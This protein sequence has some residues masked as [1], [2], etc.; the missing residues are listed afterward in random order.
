MTKIAEIEINEAIITPYTA[1]AWLDATELSGF[2]QRPLSRSV[3]QRYATEMKAGVWC[4]S[5]A[6]VI[7]MC[8]YKGT[9][10]VVLDGQ[11][12]LHAVVESGIDLVSFVAHNVPPEAFKY[13]DVG[14]PRTLSHMLT[15]NGWENPQV[16]AVVTGLLYRFEKSGD[17]IGGCALQSPGAMLDWL[18]AHHG[19]IADVYA[20]HKKA[21][22]AGAKRLY[23]QPADLLFFFYLWR[24]SNPT[25][26]YA[27]LSYFA[28]S[29]AAPPAPIYPHLLARLRE[30]HTQMQDRKAAGLQ[31]RTE[32]AKRMSMLQICFAWRVACG[33]ESYKVNSSAGYA[34]TFS[35]WLDKH[36]WLRPAESGPWVVV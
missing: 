16:L 34:R 10:D 5:T 7:R 24:K 22:N 20:D 21:I 35:N 8:E 27:L 2:P 1:R 17:P 26:A 36:D 3:I 4:E 9:P 28:D 19:E 12:R 11:H 25:D 33:A 31:V 15:S 30:G 32:V 13:I 14:A 29:K 6:D 18:I 23:V